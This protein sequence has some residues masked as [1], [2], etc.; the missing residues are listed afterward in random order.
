MLI[1]TN[2]AISSLGT[3]KHS[4]NKL[5]AEIFYEKD[6]GNIPYSKDDSKESL[7]EALAAA[8]ERYKERMLRGLNALTEEEIEEFIEEFK[9][10]YKPVN[11]TREEL[12]EFAN[13]LARFVQSLRERTKIEA[14]EMLIIS[15]AAGKT[16]SKN[17]SLE[18]LMKSM[19]TNSQ[20]Q[21]NNRAEQ[22]REA[23]GKLAERYENMLSYPMQ[24]E[25]R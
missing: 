8:I 22:N 23:V 11:G 13:K 7:A 21:F 20:W 6:S 12:D 16:E 3:N 5:R 1:N 25:R 18:S 9:L 4:N 19:T 14:N 2:T 17:D 10:K 24:E 15:S